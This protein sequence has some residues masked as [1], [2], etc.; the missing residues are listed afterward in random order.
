MCV[1]AVYPTHCSRSLGVLC[2]ISWE[3]TWAI[4][5]FSALLFFL[6]F[7]HR[8]YSMKIPFEGERPTEKERRIEINPGSGFLL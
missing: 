8:R 5:V 1:F 3:V 4:A 6:A 2:E 7:Y